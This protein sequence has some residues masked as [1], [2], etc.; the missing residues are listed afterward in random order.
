MNRQTP[1]SYTRAYSC[2][3]HSSR[4]FPSLLLPIDLQG[5]V[6]FLQKFTQELGIR[7]RWT[8]LASWQPG[9][10][11]GHDFQEGFASR[12]GNCPA[13]GVTIGRFLLSGLKR[14]DLY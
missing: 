5:L 10:S 6:N 12:V 3:L 2:R 14:D 8:E 1:S 9:A 11:E 7:N 13:A 4:R